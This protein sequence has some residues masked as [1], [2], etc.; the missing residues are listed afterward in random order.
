MTSSYRNPFHDGTLSVV[1]EARPPATQRVRLY[2]SL[3]GRLRSAHDTYATALAGGS[4][5]DQVNTTND[6]MVV[7]QTK[8]ASSPLYRLHEGF[9]EFR[10]DD[11]GTVIPSDATV[12]AVTLSGMLMAKTTDASEFVLEVFTFDFGTS[13]DAS[14]WRNTTQLK[15]L[16]KVAT[17]NTAA[18]TV[19]T[20]FDFDDVALVSAV[21]GALANRR[22]RLVVASDRMRTATTP[23]G[24]EYV[25]LYTN[26]ATGTGGSL[27]AMHLDV[28]YQPAYQTGAVEL[29]GAPC[30]QL[31]I[32]NCGPGGFGDASWRLATDDTEGP[33]H[34]LLVK[35]N[36]VTIKHGNPPVTLHEGEITK[37][38]SHPVSDGGKLYYDVTSAGLWWRAGQRKDFATVLFDDDVGQ[39]FVSPL[40]GKGYTLD[41][42]GRI[43]LGIEA[44]Q[45]TEAGKSAGVFYWLSDGLGGYLSEIREFLGVVTWSTPTSGGATNITLDYS[46]VTPFGTGAASPWVNL[47]TW[48]LGQTTTGYALR[49]DLRGLGATALRLR[50]T[51]PDGTDGFSVPRE[52][53]VWDP[54]VVCAPLRE[55]TITAV[56]K[57]N[58]TVVTTATAHGLTP[59]DRVFIHGTNSTPKVDGWRTV[60]N[61]LSST[62][63]TVAV[64]VTTAGT[65]GTVVRAWRIDEAMA[66]VA[67]GVELG[68]TTG[69]AESVQSEPIGNV[70]WNLVARPYESR[71]DTL[72][73]FAMEHHEPFDYG[74]WDGRRFVVKPYSDPPP[75]DRHFKV[76]ATAAGVEVNVFRAVEDAPAA[77]RVLYSYRAHKDA[78]D[79]NSY[80]TSSYPDGITMSAYRPEVS[81]LDWAQVEAADKHVDVWT[82][83]SDLAMTYDEAEDLADQILAWVGEGPACGTVRLSVPYIDRADGEGQMLAAYLRGGDRLD[84]VNWT[85]YEKLLIS[86]VD[87]DTERCVV[88]LGIGE[89]RDQFVARLRA[90][91]D[92]AAPGKRVKRG[93]WKA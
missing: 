10:F 67:A 56:S 70:H 46:P 25:R 19:G 24:N 45:V 43:F 93:W 18:L 37:D 21:Q 65:T 47:R 39:W 29:A 33:Y 69:L 66:E 27:K 62:G 85:G 72:N 55:A 54:C 57:A 60:Q 1:V 89:T 83:F 49:Q 7:G 13:L 3:D 58:P 82:E 87:I 5:V 28:T 38:V 75:A 26:E 22:L 50:I 92:V 52:F 36:L 15:A 51:V 78:N 40:A 30:E 88:T 8:A 11:V 74:F 42:D 79:P 32:S 6:N 2:P 71:A 35:G 91:R 23:S 31:T 90:A 64:N 59:G 14:D 20:G 4:A 86:S 61:V 68:L 34:S 77:V 63:F 80:K 17:K 16:T 9:V 44:K 53:E 84:I 76:D 81:G 73:R 41:L 48:A 12:K